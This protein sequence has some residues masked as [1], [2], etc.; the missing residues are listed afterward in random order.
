MLNVKP[1]TVWTTSHV[2]SRLVE[3]DDT[4][5]IVEAAVADW[6]AGLVS[7]CMEQ[8]FY[9]MDPDDKAT[10]KA[11]W[12]DAFEAPYKDK[13]GASKMPG[14][15]RSSKST[16]MKAIR[17][18]VELLNSDGTARGK[19]EIEKECKDKSAEGKT[20]LDKLLAALNT[21]SSLVDKA[22]DDGENLTS[23]RG[24]LADIHD[25]C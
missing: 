16:I 22:R 10:A 19:S 9:A 17:L 5:A 2:V 1:K 3:L 12:A 21:V 8:Q 6:W 25:K 14:A 7:A 11:R 24:I 15:Y 13:T 4:T 18:D 20:N 23:V